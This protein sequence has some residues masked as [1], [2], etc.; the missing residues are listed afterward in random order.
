MKKV[1]YKSDKTN[2][3]IYCRVSTDEQRQG[4]SVEVQ[5]ERLKSLLHLQ[6]L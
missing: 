5:E 3:I 4:T 1:N 2:V 6:G